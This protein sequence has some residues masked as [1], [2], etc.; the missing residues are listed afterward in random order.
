MVSNK[1][2]FKFSRI[3]Q[4]GLPVFLTIIAIFCAYFAAELLV[5]PN[6]DLNKG[7]ILLY[8]TI[9]TLS[10]SIIDPILT[11]CKVEKKLSKFT[12]IGIGILIS[13]SLFTFTKFHSSI[14]FNYLILFSK[15]GGFTAVSVSLLLLQLASLNYEIQI[16]GEKK[17]QEKIDRQNKESIKQK[18]ELIKAKKIIIEQ[19][20]IIN[21]KTELINSQNES[22]NKKK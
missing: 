16:E 15:R 13:I 19:K 8:I 9:T 12:S 7:S 10:S 22:N 3:A 20:K 2:K 11:L 18:N 5:Q 21:Q 1:R 17:N 14:F 6:K 4:D